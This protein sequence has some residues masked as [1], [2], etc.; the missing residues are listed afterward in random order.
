MFVARFFATKS[1]KTTLIGLSTQTHESVF[2]PSTEKMA[3]ETAGNEVEFLNTRES[4][5]LDQKLSEAMKHN[6]HKAISN[7]RCL[8]DTAHIDNKKKQLKVKV[9]EELSQKFNISPNCV[10]QQL[11]S[12]RTALTREIKKTKAINRNGNFAKWCLL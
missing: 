12:V 1:E 5:L 10:I 7:Y 3:D 8:W 4:D 2:S 11:H 6:L 9:L